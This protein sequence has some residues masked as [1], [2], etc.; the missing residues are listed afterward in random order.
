MN[1]AEGMR[2]VATAIADVK[3]NMQRAKFYTDMTPTTTIVTNNDR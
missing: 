2:P 3:R 1:V